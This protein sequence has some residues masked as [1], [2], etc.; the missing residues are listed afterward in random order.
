MSQNEAFA[1]LFYANTE[2]LERIQKLEAENARLRE[3]MAFLQQEYR[4]SEEP[5]TQDA[6]ELKAR[7]KILQER[8]ELRAE[9]RRLRSAIESA[10]DNL[11][12]ALADESMDREAWIELAL[13]ELEK[14]LEVRE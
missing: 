9:N 5:M 1:Q 7:L 4:D 14:A 12:L 10:S 2:K 3:D 13:E 8:D 6:L 11:S